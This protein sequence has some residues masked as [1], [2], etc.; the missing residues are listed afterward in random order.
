M[1]WVDPTHMMVLLVGIAVVAAVW[2]QTASTIQRARRRKRRDRR[3]FALGFSAGWLTATVLPR[4]RQP[5]ALRA[6]AD[7]KCRSLAI[8][9]PIVRRVRENA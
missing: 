2:L 7:I 5:R 1:E 6:V 4:R 3:M 9:A 8:A